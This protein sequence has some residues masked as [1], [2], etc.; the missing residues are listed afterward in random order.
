MAQPVHGV[1]QLPGSAVTSSTVHCYS[2][3]LLSTLTPVWHICPV[4]TAS[5]S[6][7]KPQ[8]QHLTQVSDVKAAFFQQLMCQ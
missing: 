4:L 3:V 6:D 7:N 8:Q 2:T 5:P 1:Q